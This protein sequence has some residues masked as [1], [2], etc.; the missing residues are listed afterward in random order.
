MRL[1][2]NTSFVLI[3][4]LGGADS[5]AEISKRMPTVR[6]R[7]IQRAL[8]R[9]NEG[10]LVKRQGITD[11]R[12]TLN[13]E[14]VIRQLI[15]I[16]L[17]ENISRPSSTFNF[18]LLEWLL[19]C[20][21]R[22]LA[23]I[24]SMDDWPKSSKR[25]MTKRELEFLTVELSWQSSA[26]EGNTYSL[27]DTELLLLQGIRAKNKTNFETQ[28]IL[29]H[30]A[31]IEFIIEH[32]ELFTDKITFAAVEEIHKL[33]SYNLGIDFGIRKRVV[34]ISA[35]NYEPLAAPAKLR[36]C[37]TFILSAL[38]KQRHPFAKA[39]IALS[40]MPYLQPFEDGNKRIGRMLANAI[41]IHSIGYG[42]SLRNVNAKQLALAYL[43]FY[44]F[45]S[46]DA[47]AK[48]LKAELR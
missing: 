27:L 6:L 34:K 14:G 37:A 26:L 47:L 23:V 31:A 46:L 10:E 30:K 13:Y 25:E 20:N 17:L 36:E 29:N 11:P 43:S 4:L 28:M 7:S 45:N 18:T 40:F 42:V 3:H 39:L 8:V 32:P 35:S 33:I 5:A 2:K 48:I 16:A 44:E 9:L 38:N 21:D 24:F 22:T 41:L 12:Y 1:N 19:T 15:N